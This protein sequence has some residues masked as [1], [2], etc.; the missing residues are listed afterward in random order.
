MSGITREMVH[1]HIVDI[2]VSAGSSVVVKADNLYDKG[3]T[4]AEISYLCIVYSAP[5]ST[6]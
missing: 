3:P 1:G 2:S 5:Y 4:A 6:Q